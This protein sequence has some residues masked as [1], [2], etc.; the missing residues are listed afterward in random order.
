MKVI[1]PALRTGK[2]MVVVNTRG[3]KCVLNSTPPAFSYSENPEFG[4][5][6][7]EGLK[8]L[9]RMTA[10]GL[11]TLSFAQV[12]ASDDWA[13]PLD[14]ALAW[15]RRTNAAGDRVRF[16]GGSTEFE[17]ACWWHIRDLQ[18]EVTQ[19]AEN[20]QPSRATVSWQLKE[21]VDVTANLAKARPVPKAPVAQPAKAPVLR[22]HQVVS[23]DTLWGIAARYLGNGVRWPEIFQLNAGIIGNPNLIFPGQVFQIPG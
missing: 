21:A 18:I 3:G 11:R 20:N 2:A 17:D 19:R 12:V 15:L 1:V 23:G 8:T 13:Q 22:T 9:T 10:P 5:L 7:R 6:P 16:T 4:E 14:G